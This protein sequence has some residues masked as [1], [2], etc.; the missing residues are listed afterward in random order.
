MTKLAAAWTAQNTELALACFTPDAMYMQPPDKQFYVGHRQLRPYFAALKQGTF[1]KFHH[2]W[3][4]EKTQ[5]GAGEFTFGNSLTK[6]GVTGVAI[7]TVKHKK[8]ATWREYFVT[9]SIDFN[10]FISTTGK[11]WEWHI[12]NYP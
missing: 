8:I 9:G 7:V 3:F 11:N 1:M 12:G 4:D 2:V 5:V 6:T 10:E